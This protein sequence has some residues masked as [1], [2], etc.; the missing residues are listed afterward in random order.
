MPSQDE[1]IYEHM[2]R[3]QYMHAELDQMELGCLGS[4]SRQEHFAGPT[5]KHLRGL[6]K[7]DFLSA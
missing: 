4:R 2:V 3:V 5:A 7:K 1:H 6:A